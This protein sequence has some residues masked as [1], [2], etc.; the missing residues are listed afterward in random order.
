MIRAFGRKIE[1]FIT[2]NIPDPIKLVFFYGSAFALGYFI[3][4]YGYTNYEEAIK[5]ICTLD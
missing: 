5:T 3:G 2:E 1:L 4:D